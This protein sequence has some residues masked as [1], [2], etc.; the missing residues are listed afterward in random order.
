MN[1]VE[2][3][4]LAPGVLRVET[5]ADDGKLH[6]YHVLDGPSGP[7]LVDPGYEEAPTEVYRPFLRSRGQDLGDVSLAVVTHADA[8]HFGGNHRLRN[9]NSGVPIAV[10]RA[11]APLAESRSR[12]LDERYRM[13]ESE[14]GIVYEDDV[15]EWLAEMMGPDEPIDIHLRGGEEFRVGDRTLTVLH[16]PGH[17]RGHLVLYDEASDVVVGADAFFG[18]GLFDVDGNYLQPPPYFLYPEYRN[19]VQLVSA[20]DPAVLSFTHYDVLRGD[21]VREFVQESLDFVSEIET[22]AL[23][24]VDDLGTVTLREA[25]D[26]TVERRGEFGLNDDLA[27]PLSAHYRHFVERDVLERTERDG[28]VAWERS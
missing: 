25:V 8:D 1:D 23:E 20:I 26:E 7:I 24:I 28:V 14:H 16:T 6:G 3:V 5:V 4:E 15:Y 19:T 9:H 27:Y 2:S 10:H 18:R 13:F 22:L 21:E 17:T 11:D 12:I